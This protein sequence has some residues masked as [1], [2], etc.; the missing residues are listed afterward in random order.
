MPTVRDG[1]VQMIDRAL[2]D[3][4]RA[5]LIAARQLEEECDWVT[6]RAVAL[7]RR[8]GWNWARIGRLLGMTRQGTR[9]R[10]PL[11][12]PFAPPSSITHDR[13]TQYSRETERMQNDLR[14]RRDH[15]GQPDGPGGPG[16][17][18]GPD[19]DP[20]AWRRRAGAP[21]RTPADPLQF[22][23]A[24]TPVVAAVTAVTTSEKGTSLDGGR[25][26]GRGR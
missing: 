15:P 23:E 4:P 20:I 7:A 24:V 17:Q 16:G 21:R 25:P 9:K 1:L 26:W 5:A 14:R 19:D 18:D 10:F 6:K 11:A 13:V 3:D 22:S 2:G 12:A 8:E